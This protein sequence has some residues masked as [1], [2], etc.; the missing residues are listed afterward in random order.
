MGFTSS[1]MAT[2][3]IGRGRLLRLHQAHQKISVGIRSL[4]FSFRVRFTFIFIRFGIIRTIRWHNL[5]IGSRW[6]NGFPYRN[7][8]FKRI[9][10][11]N[12]TECMLVNLSFFYNMFHLKPV[13]D[14][15]HRKIDLLLVL[16][17]FL[18]GLL[19]ATFLSQI[20]YLPIPY[21]RLEWYTQQILF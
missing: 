7:Y 11:L 6:G 19:T 9:F 8:G 12:E 1:C 2:H 13:I 18:R 21:H 4:W 16:S 3:C 5:K 14:S 20:L 10:Y 15:V 17:I